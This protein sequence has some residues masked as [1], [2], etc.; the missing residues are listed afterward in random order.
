MLVSVLLIPCVLLL[1]PNPHQR[2]FITQVKNIQGQTSLTPPR[3]IS[4]DLPLPYS[5]F[6]RPTLFQSRISLPS[7]SAPIPTLTGV[8]Y[9]RFVKVFS[10]RDKGRDYYHAIPGFLTF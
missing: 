10:H 3:F 7:I 1:V 6:L 9:R 5:Q 4:P 8:S 2:L